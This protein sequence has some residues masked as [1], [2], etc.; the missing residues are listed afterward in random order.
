[1]ELS[2]RKNIEK[3]VYD[4]IIQLNK[5]S[6]QTEI[7]S[8]HIK[9]INENLEAIL[10]YL[11]KADND[12]PI[13]RTHVLERHFMGFDKRSNLLKIAY[14]LSRFDYHIINEIFNKRFNQT[15]CF[16]YLAEKLNVKLTTLR[17]YRDIFDPYV[18]QEKS[19]RRGWYQKALS[20]E[21]QAIKNYYDTKNYSEIKTD[22][23]IILVG[24]GKI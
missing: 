1:M 7:I 2:T 16:Q 21:F 20:D 9:I 19:N 5:H 15:E 8:P 11:N 17:N 12:Y 4:S 18:K 6:F 3:L 14:A 23:E 24:K 22:I 10:N 13:Q